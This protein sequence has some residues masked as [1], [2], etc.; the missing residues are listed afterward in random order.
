MAVADM[1]VP[2][3]SPAYCLPAARKNHRGGMHNAAFRAMVCGC[4]KEVNKPYE[5]GS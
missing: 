1:N 2:P 3:F 5:A 4:V